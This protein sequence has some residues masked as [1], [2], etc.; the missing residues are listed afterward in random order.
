MALPCS[1]S[2]N[3][4]R[5]SRK[6]SFTRPPRTTLIIIAGMVASNYS[7]RC[8]HIHIK[9]TRQIKDRTQAM[10]LITSLN[11][12]QAIRITIKTRGC[13]QAEM[14]TI[15]DISAS[16]L[17]ELIW[18]AVCFKVTR[19]AFHPWLAAS[20]TTNAA[21]VAKMRAFSRQPHWKKSKLI[22]PTLTCSMIRLRTGTLTRQ[23][24]SIKSMLQDKPSTGS[25]LTQQKV[26]SKISS[27]HQISNLQI[28][29]TLC[30]KRLTRTQ[31]FRRCKPLT[32]H[33]KI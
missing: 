25:V 11:R 24:S 28:C 21:K 23:H 26:C 22:Q 14:A 18:W 31:A 30:S 19:V 33:T 16:T 32:S 15:I 13:V 12:L 5:C 8:P 4:C 2:S 20:T 10:S 29:W 3:N 27:M 7:L 9:P 1:N 17:M 6:I